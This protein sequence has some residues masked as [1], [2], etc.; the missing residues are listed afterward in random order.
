MKEVNKAKAALLVLRKAKALA[1]KEE[2]NYEL[3]KADKA[4]KVEL[5]AKQAA[6]ALF[7][8]S[9]KAWQAKTRA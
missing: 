5:A 6:D 4:L 7:K 2:A 3:W 8:A 9:K 1:E